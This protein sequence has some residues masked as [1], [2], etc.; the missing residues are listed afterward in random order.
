MR[1]HRLVGECLDQFDLALV[2]R[3][4]GRACQNENTR[5]AA[6]ADQRDA[7]EAPEAADLRPAESVFRVVENVRDVHDRS[8]QRGARSD[9]AAPR[10]HRVLA[11]IF[12]EFLR[13]ADLHGRPENLTVAQVDAAHGRVTEIGRGFHQRVQH[14]VEIERRGADRL[15]HLGRCRLLL[16][17]FASTRTVRKGHVEIGV[18]AVPRLRRQKMIVNRVIIL[19]VHEAKEI[20]NRRFNIRDF[21]A[22]E[23]DTKDHFSVCHRRRVSFW[24]A[25]ARHKDVFDTARAVEF[26]HIHSHGTRRVV[27]LTRSATGRLGNAR[28]IVLPPSHMF[29][30]HWL[31]NTLMNVNLLSCRST[32]RSSPASVF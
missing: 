26:G 17:R 25:A 31:N 14:S 6:I 28:C 29:E 3:L 21:L 16:K 11:H 15:Q 30:F 8:R 19:P 1:D 24:I 7:E 20:P 9:G 27:R 5:H 4:H 10:T 18:H 32:C 12:V 13:P 2:E 22:I 23:I